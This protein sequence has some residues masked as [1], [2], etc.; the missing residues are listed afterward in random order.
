M[1]STT[2]NAFGIL[3]KAIIAKHLATAGLVAAMKGPW[4][5]SKPAENALDE[6]YVIIVPDV[7]ID[8]GWTCHRRYWLSEPEFRFFNKTP[9]LCN[10]M[11]DLW[12]ATFAS[13]SLSL[14]FAAGGLVQHRVTRVNSVQLEPQS[15]EYARC[16]MKF[17]TWTPRT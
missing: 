7:T 5:D 15:V 13:E 4:K 3:L 11:M 8:A 9:D 10:T 1:P 2:D 17:R 6:K 16:S 12:L 14:T